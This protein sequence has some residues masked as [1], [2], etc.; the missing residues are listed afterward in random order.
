MYSKQKSLRKKSQRLE[1][2]DALNA[3]DRTRRAEIVVQ[4]PIHGSNANNIENRRTKESN[5]S[6][7]SSGIGS[8]HLRV[9]EAAA[10]PSSDVT[11]REAR[12]ET[13][14]PDSDGEIVPV[15]GNHVNNDENVPSDL[16]NSADRDSET[17]NEI[18]RLLEKA[19]RLLQNLC[20][21][22]RGIKAKKKCEEKY[23]SY[24]KRIDEVEWR[25]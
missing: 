25:R 24:G 11:R 16:A 3:R 15:E 19:N 4:Y 23:A 5:S 8:L 6:A 1:A 21:P 10:H 22:S 13:I 7:S 2:N 9:E 18:E 14:I 17:K 12:R 20:K